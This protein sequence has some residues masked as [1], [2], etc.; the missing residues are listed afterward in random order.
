[1][2]TVNAMHSGGN[3][4]VSVLQ[5]DRG[6]LPYVE[7]FLRTYVFDVRGS[8]KAVA[9]APNDARIEVVPVDDTLFDLD[10][11]RTTKAPGRKLLAYVGHN[12]ERGLLLLQ[13]TGGKYFIEV[14][15]GAK[16][17]EKLRHEVAEIRQRLYEESVAAAP[18]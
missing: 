3:V 14:S 11:V 8:G 4:E 1:M 15:D 2:S 7:T 16:V 18:Q 17:P 10:R 6:I 12:S 9:Y 13:T 5:K